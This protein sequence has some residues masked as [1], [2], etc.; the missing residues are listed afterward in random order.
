MLP[1]SS[2]RALQHGLLLLDFSWLFSSYQLN[3][4]HISPTVSSPSN[5]FLDTFLSVG[6]RAHTL[7]QATWWIRGLNNWVHEL[8]GQMFKGR[9]VQTTKPFGEG[10]KGAMW[11]RKLYSSKNLTS[12]LELIL[13]RDFQDS[14]VSGIV[15]NFKG[16][17]LTMLLQWR[18]LA[19]MTAVIP[20]CA[21]GQGFLQ[22]WELQ[23]FL[24]FGNM[25]ITCHITHLKD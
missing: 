8:C 23:L 13:Q 16:K 24:Q 15:G 6:G 14:L 1:S 12:H 22:P 4:S 11:K 3:T 5:N 9:K 2:L 7:S 25:Q 20:P 19:S 17:N 18:Y 21:I 10:G